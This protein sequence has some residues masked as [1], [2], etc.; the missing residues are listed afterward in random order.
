[1]TSFTF[2]DLEPASLERD[3]EL[4]GQGH[5]TTLIAK[6]VFD[7]VMA[8]AVAL[9]IL[10]WLIPLLALLIKLTSKGPALFVQVRS[11]LNGEQ[12]KC[13]KFRTMAHN[14]DAQFQQASKNDY[15]VTP[16]GRILRKTNLDEV[17]QF[18][19]VLAGQMS[20]VGPRPHP[21]PLDAKYWDTMPRYAERYNVKPGITG[22]AQVRGARGETAHLGQMRNRVRYDHLYIQRQSL[23]L[24]IRICWWTIKAALHGNPNAW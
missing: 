8:T 4:T 6:R 1:M 2:S 7:I 17:P 19:N 18:L 9:L 11:G 20:L 12:F 22:L 15:R 24:D 23:M 10:T 13:L 3:R 21:L 16:V 14:P 5:A